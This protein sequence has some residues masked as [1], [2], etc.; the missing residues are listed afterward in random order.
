MRDARLGAGAGL[1]FVLLGIASGPLLPQP[2][3]AGADATTVLHYFAGHETR[4]VTA[5]ML[6]AAAAVSLAFF[7]GALATRLVP[8]RLAARA[9]STG[10][11][12][13]VAVSV[14][15]AIGLA[16]VARSAQGLGATAALRAAFQVER[17]VFF[18]APALGMAIVAAAAAR[19][20]ARAGGPGWLTALSAVLGLVG[21]GAGLAGVASGSSAVAG[22][23]FAGFLLTIVWVL[24]VS[25]TLWR[26]PAAA[27]ISAEQP[28]RAGSPSAVP[29]Y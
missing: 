27:A 11:A 5:S 20:I 13:V 6:A 23:G 17:G 24:G 28:I 22:F 21:L 25:I 10:G 8:D 2:P 3:D 14:L 7:F 26:R 12:I 18:V 16:A 4:I 9:I 1:L 19:G 15:G 29:G